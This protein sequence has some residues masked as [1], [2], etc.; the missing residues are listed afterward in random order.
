[1]HWFQRGSRIYIGPVTD[2][3]MDLLRSRPA[4]EKSGIACQAEKGKVDVYLTLP[5]GSN[6]V[7]MLQDLRK[8]AF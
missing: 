1:M 2:L 7:K 6:T 5:V 3:Q 4:L 8:E